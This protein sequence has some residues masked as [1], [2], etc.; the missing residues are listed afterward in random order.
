MAINLKTPEE[1]EKMKAL[2]RRSMEEGALG[3]STGLYYVP[4]NFTPPEEVIELA[5]VAGEMGGIH[6]SH[7]R[8]EADGVLNSVRETITF[9]NFETSGMAVA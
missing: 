6:T 7:M 1:I 8:N 3:M 2:V 9:G 5:R 4:G